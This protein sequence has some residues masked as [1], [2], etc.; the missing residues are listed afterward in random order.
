MDIRVILWEGKDRMHLTQDRDQWQDFEN[1][2]TN[3]W[4]P[5]KRGNFLTS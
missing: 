2:V 3:L 1:K 4:V 5:Q